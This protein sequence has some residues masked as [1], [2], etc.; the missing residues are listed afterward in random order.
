MPSKQKQSE[1]STASFVHLLAVFLHFGPDSK[2]SV[3]C[4]SQDIC[5]AQM[6]GL[7]FIITIF[8]LGHNNLNSNSV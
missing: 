8:G 2:L 1:D 5:H 7:E 3:Y 6:T 4:I